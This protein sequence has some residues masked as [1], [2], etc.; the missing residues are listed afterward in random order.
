MNRFKTFFGIF[1][2][3]SNMK[4]YFENRDI[5]LSKKIKIR[6]SNCIN[7]NKSGPSKVFIFQGVR[8]PTF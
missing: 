6:V 7:K 8:F 2:N 1:P 5:Q 4:P 3:E